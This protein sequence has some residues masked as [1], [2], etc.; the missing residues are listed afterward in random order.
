MNRITLDFSGCKK[1]NDVY[2][3]IIKKCGLP[4][5]CGKNLDGLWDFMEDEFV[6]CN[7]PTIITIINSQKIPK[8]VYNIVFDEIKKLVFD[9]ITKA[10]PNVKFEIIS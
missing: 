3:E 9:D 5:C 1:G 8:D 4:E 2:D 6:L 10:A 7:N